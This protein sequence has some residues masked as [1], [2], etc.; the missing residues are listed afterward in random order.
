MLAFVFHDVGIENELQCY[1]KLVSTR[2]AYEA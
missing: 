2:L 1:P